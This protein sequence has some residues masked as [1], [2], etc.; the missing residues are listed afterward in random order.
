MKEE[1]PLLYFPKRRKGNKLVD[2][3]LLVLVKATITKSAILAQKMNLRDLS[4][5][6]NYGKEGYKQDR[7]GMQWSVRTERKAMKLYPAYISLTERK[8]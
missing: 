5:N 8:E 4:S 6:S 7:A 3:I 1:R 2:W